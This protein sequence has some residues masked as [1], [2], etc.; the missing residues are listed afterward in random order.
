LTTPT[1]QNPKIKNF[2]LL[3][4]EISMLLNVDKAHFVINYLKSLPT[5]KSGASYTDNLDTDRLVKVYTAVKDAG[6]YNFQ[7]AKIALP[8][9]LN[10][11]AWQILL[12]DYYDD[13][14]CQFLEYGFPTGYMG[15]EL[16]FE[17]VNNHPSAQNFSK[18]IDNFILKEIRTCSLSGP[19]VN[20]VLPHTHL[21]P[22]MTRPKVLSSD[23]RVI[24]D[25]SHP[26][27]ASFNDNVPQDNYLND[28]TGMSLP[29]PWDL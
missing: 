24:V 6:R 28:Y 3:S 29:T 10:H 21:S 13:R 14:L 7:G 4:Q 1:P 26:K 5:K 11:E 18:H 15:Q 25:L 23:R 12:H 17:P 8:S 9:N 20:P 19:Y 2:S 16:N 27:G 22:L